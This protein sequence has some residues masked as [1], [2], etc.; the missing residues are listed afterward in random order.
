GKGSSL[1][2]GRGR[3]VAMRARA[4]DAGR[5]TAGPDRGRFGLIFYLKPYVLNVMPSALVFL[6]LPDAVN[7]SRGQEQHVELA[8]RVAK[9][10]NCMYLYEW[11]I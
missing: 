4:Q 5:G 9:M 7:I 6:S 2:V 10:L 3:A 1:G 11:N 8:H